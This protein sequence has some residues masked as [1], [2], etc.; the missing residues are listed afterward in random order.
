MKL[1][2]LNEAEVK[3]TWNAAIVGQ[4]QSECSKRKLAASQT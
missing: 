4:T 2:V 1:H 3:N